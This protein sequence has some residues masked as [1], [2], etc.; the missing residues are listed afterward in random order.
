MCSD[1]LPYVLFLF[2][3]MLLLLFACLFCCLFGFQI[4]PGK[5]FFIVLAVWGWSWK[6]AQK[7]LLWWFDIYLLL[8]ARMIHYRFFALQEGAD[9]AQRNNS[10][11][12]EKRTKEGNK[13]RVTISKTRP[14]L[15]AVLSRWHIGAW[16]TRPVGC[17]PPT[18][19]AGVVCIPG[20]NRS[21]P[22]SGPKV[23]ILSGCGPLPVQEWDTQHGCR[24]AGT[25]LGHARLW[26]I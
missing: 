8:T 14:T 23:C 10:K 20:W 21:C 26:L 12:K 3:C 6:L 15:C 24:A 18:P 13:W 22:S 19:P 16:V 5:P 17:P 1:S 2:I 25:A 9:P 4:F 11:L 7:F